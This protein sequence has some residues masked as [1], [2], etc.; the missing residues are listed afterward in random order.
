[1]IKRSCNF[2]NKQSYWTFTSYYSYIWWT[3][4]D[5][6]WNQI[7]F[8]FF[9]QEYPAIFSLTY[10]LTHFSLS[11]TSFIHWQRQNNTYWFCLWKIYILK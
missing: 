5:T 1:M 7:D 11:I 3:Y 10:Q 4:L 9:I 6:K 2:A 8:S